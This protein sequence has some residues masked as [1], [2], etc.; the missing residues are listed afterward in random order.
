ME[1]VN[2][3]Y[4]TKNIPFPNQKAYKSQ[5]V[6]KMEAVIKRMRWKAKFFISRS[7]E[8]DPVA[9]ENYGLKS[10]M[11]PPPVKEMAQFEIELLQ[12]AKDLEFRQPT[13]NFQKRLKDDITSIRR[14]RKT[15]TPADKTSNMYRLSKEE[16]ERLKTNAITSKYKKA[17]P[18]IKDKIEKAGVKFAK[19]KGVFNRMEKNGKNECFI[20]LKDHKPNFQNHPTTRLIN[21][22]KNEIGRISKVI[23]DDINK[24]L[25]DAIGV[26]QW[27][28]TGDVIEWFTSIPNKR[29]HT[30]TVF[31]IKDFYPSI[32]ESLLKE[33][34]AFANQHVRIK[35]KDFDL[36][37]H[38]RKSL[39]FGLGDTWIKKDGGIFDVTMGAYDGAEVCELVGTYL[40][41]ILATKTGRK[42]IGLYRDDGLAVFENLSGPQNEKMKKDIQ[43]I[44]RDKGLDIV[45]ECNKKIVDYLDATMDLNNGTHKPYRKPGDETNYIHTESDHPPSIIKQLPVSVEARLS[46]LSS[47]ER[48][49][50]E[51]KDHYQEVLAKNGYSHTLQYK[52][53]LENQR[54]RRK[55]NVIWFNPPFSKIV[56]TNVGKKFLQLVDKHFPRSSKFAKIFNRNTLKVSYGCMPNMSSIISSHNKKI[57]KEV[58]P[59]NRGGCNCQRG[60]HRNNCPLNGECLT[61]NVLYE[62]EVTSN[63][64]AY[65]KK[66]YKGITHNEFKTREGNHELTFRDRAYEDK[67]ELS[68]EIWNIKDKEGTY[69]I[70]W[71]IISLNPPYNPATKRCRLCI[72]E[73]VEI[74]ESDSPNLLNK[75]SELVSKCPHMNKFQLSNI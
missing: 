13:N 72:S 64:P 10:Q 74:L 57:L 45:I 3:G 41:S 5:L 31:D 39:L 63:L 4:S 54:R 47:S 15:L 11:C 46:A 20:T 51:A 27:K 67:T 58:S 60:R 50:N 7:E 19:D 29:N 48:E 35:K 14:S 12:I 69:D 56:K 43:K 8:E 44:F 21:P 62:A 16:Y 28:C 68:K 75:R 61:P 66:I 55:R 71:R 42:N 17:S 70:K 37:M 9:V 22:S 18:K 25:K 2:L 40:L 30:F 23:L 36:I 53:R 6:E 33:A 38:A 32:T 24:K 65:G 49:F 73:K 34:L 59:L 1:K 26:N 52:P